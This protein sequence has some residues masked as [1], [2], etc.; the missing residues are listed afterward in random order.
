M[1]FLLILFIIIDQ[2]IKERVR[3]IHD[4]VNTHNIMITIGNNKN[5][6]D[7]TRE[8]NEKAVQMNKHRVLTLA[9]TKR[10]IIKKCKYMRKISTVFIIILA[11]G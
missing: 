7:I 3:L 5:N 10:T 9:T 6:N 8:M 11:I 2:L 4:L 1:F